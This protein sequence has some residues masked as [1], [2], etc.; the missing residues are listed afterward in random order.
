MEEVDQIET[1]PKSKEAKQ[2]PKIP[3]G[4]ALPNGTS[5]P[6]SG[7][8][9]SRNFSVTSGLSDRSLSTEDSTAPDTTP[10]NITST[11]PQ[12]APATQ[13]PVKAHEEE[14]ETQK[15]QPPALQEEKDL[16]AKNPPEKEETESAT[17]VTQEIEGNETEVPDIEIDKN[18]VTVE[19]V[20][21]EMREVELD[22]KT[23]VLEI[24]MDKKTETREDKA[25]DLGAL[26]SQKIEEENT[27][28]TGPAETEEVRID[29]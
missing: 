4:G 23:E 9:S 2:V 18:T 15:A 19:P 13:S 22:K 28:V 25:A 7:H 24:E 17:E 1:E 16:Q 26:E 3:N 10:K 8:P 21:T 14:L 5:S 12:L 27:S 11:P 6:D 20:E 29:Q